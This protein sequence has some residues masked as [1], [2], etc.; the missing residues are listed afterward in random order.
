MERGR[1]M[2]EYFIFIRFSQDCKVLHNKHATTGLTEIK[3]LLTEVY[4]FKDAFLA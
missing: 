3:I 2:H 4:I 1:E